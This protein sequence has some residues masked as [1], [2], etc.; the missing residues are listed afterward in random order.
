M[1]YD[2]D[3]TG[4]WAWLKSVGSADDPLL[5][6]WLDGRSYLLRSVWFP[7]HPRSIRAGDLLVY[8]AAGHLRVPA[9][10]EVESDEVFE[11][12]DHPRY[13]ERWPW[14]MEVKPLVVVPRVSDAPTLSAMRI[15]HLRVRQQSHILLTTEELAEFRTALVPATEGG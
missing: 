15:D 13:S 7:K 9:V 5:D 6:D 11:A 2:R 12:R 10:V 14:R 4:R 1:A 3:G 8:Y